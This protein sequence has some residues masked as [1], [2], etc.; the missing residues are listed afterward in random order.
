MSPTEECWRGK[1]NTSEGARR[2]SGEGVEHFRRYP[3]GRGALKGGEGLGA[4]EGK[5]A[6][7]M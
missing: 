7:M 6:G 3:K 5:G 1:P 4:G 2:K